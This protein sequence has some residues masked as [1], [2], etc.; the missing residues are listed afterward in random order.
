MASASIRFLIMTSEKHTSLGQRYG[1]GF[2]VIIGIGD[3]GQRDGGDS[4]DG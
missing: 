1:F 2:D 3:S 4:Q